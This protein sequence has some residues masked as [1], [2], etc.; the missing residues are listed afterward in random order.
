L[1]FVEIRGRE[2]TSKDVSLPTQLLILSALG[3]GK[4]SS[5]WQV[6]RESLGVSYRQE[7]VLWPTRTGFQ[8]RLV[9]LQRQ[10]DGL[11]IAKIVRSEL[12][13]AVDRWEEGDLQR[14]V[15]F[16]EGCLQTGL[17]AFPLYVSPSHSITDSLADQAFL[18]AYW[19]KKTGSAWNP[20]ALLSA[21]KQLD[22]KE[23]KSEAKT[24]ILSSE[25][26]AVPRR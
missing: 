21:A 18:A 16:L 6:M 9:W 17:A 7:A 23:L 12:L 4:G 19:P 14:A 26:A 24:W 25:I 3:S 15:Q 20:V 22:V 2:I 13:A 11:E 1:H 10:G 8:G 5:L